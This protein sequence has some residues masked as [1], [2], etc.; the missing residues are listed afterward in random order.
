MTSSNHEIAYENLIIL[1]HVMLWEDTKDNGSAYEL[2]RM[3]FYLLN[4]LFN[5][6]TKMLLMKY[7][8]YDANSFLADLASMIENTR[9]SY[10]PS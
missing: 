4:T 1:F 5:P 3:Y 10:I 6:V 9:L 8:Y 7:L 2:K